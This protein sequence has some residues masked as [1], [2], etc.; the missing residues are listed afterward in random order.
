[1]LAPFFSLQS[2]PKYV[3]KD[4]GHALTMVV[5]PD[6]SVRRSGR[7]TKGQHHKKDEE[8]EPPT[9]KRG[10]GSKKKQAS[11]EATPPAEDDEDALI[12]CICGV[13]E[14]DDDAE[15]TMICCDRCTAW[16]HNDCMEIT[17]NPD[18]LP[19]QYFCEQC[20]PEDHQGLLA[21]IARGE[22]PWEEKARQR[23]AEAAE[24][25]ARRRKGKKGRR[26]RPSEVKAESAKGVNGD[27]AAIEPTASPIKNTPTA[28]TPQPA[29]VATQTPT[30]PST[31]PHPPPAK[32]AAPIPAPD[33]TQPRPTPE[34]PLKTKSTSETGHKRKLR[35]ETPSSESKNA[36]PVSTFRIVLMIQSLISLRNPLKKCAKYHLQQKTKPQIIVASQA[37]LRCL[38]KMERQRK[39][40]RKWGL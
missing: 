7:A 27:T 23:E 6:E 3:H 31:A 17:E 36:E 21:K 18:E 12:R 32:L 13:I 39:E 9:P 16:Q 10:K 25:K 30:K 11:A 1:M 26:G 4:H 20:K 14:D 5:P 22:K 40:G 15:R 38:R 19:E 37:L 29:R 24:R 2:K 34:M 28:V 35:V 33:T 8:L